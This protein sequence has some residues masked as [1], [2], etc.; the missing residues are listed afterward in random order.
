MPP[1]RPA[2]A[3]LL[4]RLGRAGQPRQ[5]GR[6]I[7]EA[8]LP[9]PQLRFR[10]PGQ[11]RSRAPRRPRTGLPTGATATAARPLRRS[12]RACWPR[13]ACRPCSTRSR[14]GPIRVGACRGRA[15]HRRGDR[16]SRSPPGRPPVLVRHVLE[17]AP[18]RPPR[19]VDQH[20]R[21]AQRLA[22]AASICSPA[23]VSVTSQPRAARPPAARQWSTASSRRSADRATS[24]T[25][26]PSAHSCRPV[27]SPMP[28]LAP[29]TTHT[30]PARPRSTPR[31]LKRAT[32]AAVHD[33]RAGQENRAARVW[34]LML[35]RFCRQNRSGRYQPSRTAEFP[36]R[37]PGRPSAGRSGGTTLT[38]GVKEGVLGASR[39]A[40]RAA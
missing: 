36:P 7:G 38:T 37:R 24:S 1:D 34:M 29:V 9:D 17:I 10:R 23:S 20:L 6:L 22:R 30:F 3:G 40:G 15:P 39:R 35:R 13:V 12:T 25:A 4:E 5:L 32:Q 31:S 16:P 19:V 2:R 14:P 21:L 27:S 33:G 26:A 18:P 11:I 8:A 28:R